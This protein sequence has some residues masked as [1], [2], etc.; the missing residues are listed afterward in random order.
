MV[1]RRGFLIE[2][3]ASLGSVT[4]MGML[5]T[6]GRNPAAEPTALASD[7]GRGS[8]PRASGPAEWRK[9]FPTLDQRVNGLPLVYLDT[10]A[11]AMRPREV[12]EAVADF[13][14]YDNAN[15]GGTLHTLARRANDRFTEARRT[16]AQFIGATDPLEVVFTRGTTEAVNLAAA[17]WG[18]ANLKPGDTVLI[19]KGEHSSNM[20]PWQAIARRMG[21]TVMYFDVLGDGHVDLEDY[22][23]HLGVR[24]KIVAFSHV[25]NVLGIINPAK[26]MVERAHRTG[27]IVLVDAAQSMP[28][29]TVSVRE[30]G[31]DFLAFSG[32]KIC[33]P[34][35]SGALWARRELLDAMPPYQSG[36]N[37]AHDVDLASYHPSDGALKFGAGTPS[38]ADAVGLAAAAGFLARVGR[39]AVREHERQITTRMLARLARVRGLTL[40]GGADANTRIALFSFTIAGREPADVLAALDARGIAVRAGDL[41]SLP[42]L[43]QFGVTSAVRASCYL[44][45]TLAEVDAFADALEGRA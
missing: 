34:M 42:L 4:T 43:K 41:A 16:V 44:Y 1:D 9:E 33:G 45:T 37:M 11:T 20:L 12:I 8:A 7:V 27:A 24:P 17:S 25:S 26:E 38:V 5:R 29:I 15:P 18:G 23:R 35:G 2:G 30:L 14:R 40:L 3:A 6:A 13:Y 10:A 39:E 31:C 28:H 22:E 32:H 21:A 19:G 36:S